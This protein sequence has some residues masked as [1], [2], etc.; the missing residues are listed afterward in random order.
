MKHSIKLLLFFYN[1]KKGGYLP[2]VKTKEK[3]LPNSANL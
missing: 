2:P 3:E 1:P